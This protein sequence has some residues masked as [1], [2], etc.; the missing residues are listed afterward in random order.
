MSPEVV[1]KGV[2][3]LLYRGE[4]VLIMVLQEAEVL[5]GLLWHLSLQGG[6]AGAGSWG[7]G[8]G[9]VGPGRGGYRL[10]TVL[11]TA[12]VGADEVLQLALDIVE[13]PLLPALPLLQHQFLGLLQHRTAL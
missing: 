10:D 2:A 7:R 3:L 13:G 11:H 4:A 6:Q 1:R 12:P 5:S 8:L 9:A